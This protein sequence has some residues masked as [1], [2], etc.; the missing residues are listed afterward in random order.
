MK[1]INDNMRYLQLLAK[2]FPNVPKVT[3]EIIN[4]E[5]ILQLPKSTEHF[6]A[7]LH[8]ENEAFQHVLRNA[9]GNIK[10]KV[11]ETFDKYLSEQE[12]KE[13]CTLIY[14]PEEKLE[15]VK[16]EKRD[17]S[18]F[19]QTTLN[20]LI[21]VCRNVSSKYT[22]S[23]VRK[24]LPEQFAFIIEE[25]LHESSD[26]HNKHEYY[27]IIVRTI[28]RTRRAEPFIVQLCYLIQ[29]LAIDRLHI[30]GDIF[31]RGPGAHL[32]MD[33]LC[34][35]HN[36][37]IQWGNHDILWMGAAAGN[38]ACAAAVIRLSLRY[39]NTKTLED[40]Y[41]INMVPLATFAMETYADDP[42]DIFKPFIDFNGE[43]SPR[44]KTQR[45]IAQM[46]KAIA[47]IQ[48]KLES[49]LYLQNPDWKMSDRCLLEKMDFEN[50]TIEYNGKTY[51]IEDR[52]F[53]TIDKDNPYCLNEEEQ[54]IMDS[55]VRSFRTSERLQ[56]HMQCLLANGGM[57]AVCN[58]NLLFHASMP[59]NEDGTLR[60]VEIQGQTY[61]GKELMRRI[62]QII[63][64]AYEEGA[65]DDE[66]AYARDFFWY[67]WCGPDSPL[68]D[69]SKMTTFE[70]YFINNKEVHIEEK[71]WYFK[72]RD[73]E[74]VCERLLD[75]FEVDGK[76]RHII[77]GH[78][79]VKVGKGENPIKAGGR[80]MVIDGGFARAYHSTTGIAGYTLVYHSRGFQ[81]VQH[82]P[83][84]STEEA[85]REGIDIQSTTSIVETSNRRV[86][87]ADTDIGRELRKQI[88]ELE[89]LLRA[90]RKGWLKEN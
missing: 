71:G 17:M 59:L 82:A 79:P 15:M 64:L 44:Q 53:P 32:I 50:G 42:C 11:Q 13:L 38:P 6:L 90:Y 74:D 4:L 27:N 10:R 43:N 26:G 89:L 60:E 52:Y 68:F 20:R 23:K 81:L 70:R 83:F 12:I 33:T 61:K 5:A 88:A 80:L 76:Y 22:R 67:L 31:D 3:T 21:M 75:D 29:R 48:F 25:L 86:L 77:N 1:N 73:R 65:E 63:R 78:V 36:L 66:R 9:S 51:P 2:E 24:S 57:Y 34:N 45:L 37:D 72:L 39:A 41:G 87:V 56:R 46:H 85:V 8:G 28:I 18:D 55:L 69:K 7:D 58:S 14:Y 62:E 30:L 54:E 40:G 16:L 84:T 19:Y 35:Y 47:V 49:Q